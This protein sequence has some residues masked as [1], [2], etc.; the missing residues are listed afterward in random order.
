MLSVSE[1]VVKS[2]TFVVFA[3]FPAGI[4]QPPFF[5][6]EYPNSVNFG[7][8]GAVIG[9]EITHG[10]DDQ[11]CNYDHDGNLYNWWHAQ[12]RN[13]FNKRK[14]CMIDQY[15]SFVV[16]NISVKNLRVSICM[17]CERRGIFQSFVQVRGAATQGEN[18]ADNG[19]VKEAF[20]VCILAR[21]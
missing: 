19:G 18:I 16:P 20:R 9:H 2:R 4:L 11:G 12:A 8:I 1:G 10:F 3:V 5:D 6:R 15:N 17:L 7:A 13:G 14:Q 21:K